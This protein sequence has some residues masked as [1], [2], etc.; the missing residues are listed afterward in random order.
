MGRMGKI[1][2]GS[3]TGVR[4]WR[5]LLLALLPALIAVWVVPHFVTQDG[6]AHLYNA[7]IL[8]E[9]LGRD[10]PFEEVYEVRWQAL[11]NWAGHLIL[12][13]LV[14]VLPPIVADRALTSLTLIG[15]AGAVFWLRRR[16]AGSGG[17]WPSALLASL[18]GLNVTWLLGFSNFLIGAML[19]PVTLGFWW[20]GRNRPGPFWT[21][22]MATLLVLGYFGHLVSLGLTAFGLLVLA[23]ASPGPGWSQRLRWTLAALAPLIPL[24]IYYKRLTTEGGAFRPTWGNLS[25]PWSPGAWFAQLG[26]VDPITLGSRAS[27]PFVEGVS[28]PGFGLLAPVVW[29]AVA[30]LIL[31]I[32][33]RWTGDRRAWGGLAGLLLVGG[34]VG[35]DRFG[36]DHGDYL[37]QRVVLLGLLA[38]LPALDLD[39]SRRPVRM[40]TA[41][42]GLALILQT[43]FVWDYARESSRRIGPMIR[44]GDQLG[45]GERVGTLLVG[46][47]GRFRANPLMHADNLLGV[48]TGNILWSNY[49]TR[50]YYFPVRVKEGVAHPPAVEF[51]R[52]ARLDGP[53]EEAAR[54]DRWQKLLE[55]HHEVIDILLVR[56]HDPRLEAIHA[57]WFEP[58]SAPSEDGVRVLRHRVLEESNRAAPLPWRP[59]DRKHDIE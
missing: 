3:T 14:A 24:A 38:L 20:M 36:P 6:P 12:M 50:F 32:G 2:A 37:G 15:F 48:G 49:E 45:R 21:L 40:A 56:G 25:R 33:T 47:R 59:D 44:I 27:L 41:V 57:R 23:L 5:T 52:V 42:L 26:W 30:L 17:E 35:P 43:A 46:L 8:V 55:E 29:L 9:S 58:G 31:V 28:S 22:T 51:E 16:V 54:A 11:P 4:A 7:H 34:I 18:L 10:S 1:F 19:F 13:A 39:P 53:V